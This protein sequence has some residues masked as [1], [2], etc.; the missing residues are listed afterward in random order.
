M[1]NIQYN[2]MKAVKTKGT[3]NCGIV[4]MAPQNK[5]KHNS[6]LDSID[7]MYIYFC[8]DEKVGRQTSLNKTSLP[9][10]MQVIIYL[11][12]VDN[13]Y[14]V[15]IYSELNHSNHFKMPPNCIAQNESNLKSN[16]L[17]PTKRE[18]GNST[19]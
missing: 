3:T 17:E 4:H 1:S 12:V 18:E 19:D 9:C 10:S 16:E 13:V 6:Q 8:H 7:T 2:T 11:S 14:Y 15:S 5:L